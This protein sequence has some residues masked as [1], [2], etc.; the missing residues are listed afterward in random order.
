[1]MTPSPLPATWKVPPVFRDRLGRQA[2]RQRAMFADGHLLLV[3]H[4]P[5]TTDTAVREGRFFWREP[6]GTWHSSEGGTGPSVVERHLEQYAK[7]IVTFDQQE[8]AAHST[9]AY[10]DVLNGLS[11]LLRATR[12]MH[13]TLQDA[14]KQCPEAREIINFRDRAYE[15]ERQAELLC[16]DA[17]NS[18][19]YI[20]AKRAEEQAE[21]GERMAAAAYR[22]NLLVA[23]F[24]PVATLSAVFGTN[25]QHTL[26]HLAPPWPFLIMVG[27]GLVAGVL[28]QQL[29][30]TRSGR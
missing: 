4:A 9:E 8:E 22:L 7:A 21:N 29:V 23:F 2:G 30:T 10:F 15:L 26:E 20:V 19:D 16:G 27:L 5:P 25:L 13:D 1:M 12:H 3:L 18:L 28:L 17:K 14:R 24:F 6:D 11:P